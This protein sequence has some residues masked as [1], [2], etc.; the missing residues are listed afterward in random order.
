MT[1]IDTALPPPPRNPAGP[2]PPRPPCS[3]RRTTSID[4]TWPDGRWR[5]MTLIGRARDIV[6]E[7]SGGTPI[8]IAQDGFRAQL[9]SDRTILA[10]NTEPARAAAADLVGTRGGGHLRHA[11]D[12]V[13]PEERRAATPLHLILDDISGTSLVAGWAWSQWTD[14]WLGGLQS[15]MD[16]GELARMLKSRE[17]ICT[18]FAPGSSALALGPNRG[19]SGGAPTPSLRNPDDPDGWHDFP[20]Q[21][22]VSMRRARR[23]DVTLGDAVTIDA[24]FQDSASRPDGT[25]M[26]LHEYRLS[27]AA[28]PVSRRVTSIIAEPR[29]LP[30]PECPSATRNVTRLLGTPLIDLREKVL[31]ELRGT[32]GC[33]H[34][35]DALRALA[36][37]PALLE[38]LLRHQELTATK[39]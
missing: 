24:A 18:G 38:H 39:R 35:N 32:A 26:A 10:I 12:E 11:I 37:V 16:P 13:M 3:A 5:D 17:G 31:E 15:R 33:T 7:R 22:G 21:E 6:T 19:P 23:I 29:V 28:D 27:V 25:R 4:V 30:F 34:L 20:V 14:D 9:K 36:A 8:V 1:T 2:A